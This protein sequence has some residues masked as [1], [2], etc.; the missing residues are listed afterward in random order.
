MPLRECLAYIHCLWHMITKTLLVAFI[1]CKQKLDAIY[2]KFQV[3]APKSPSQEYLFC[4]LICYYVYY[5]SLKSTFL[6]QNNALVSKAPPC[7]KLDFRTW[8]FPIDPLEIIILDCDISLLQLFPFISLQ[9]VL[10]V[11]IEQRRKQRESCEW[12]CITLIHI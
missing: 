4:C 10:K 6:S 9:R 2:F 1:H 7:L 8:W 11:R 12:Q 3:S 5:Y